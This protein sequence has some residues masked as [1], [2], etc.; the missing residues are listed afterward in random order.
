MG[1]LKH[2]RDWDAV[3]RWTYERE[4]DTASAPRT[5][6]TLATVSIYDYHSPI[7]F[8]L[9]N[10]R[11]TDSGMSEITAELLTQSDGRSICAFALPS[12]VQAAEVKVPFNANEA[13][14]TWANGSI[15]L[16]LT[17]KNYYSSASAEIPLDVLR[18]IAAQG[19]IMT[20]TF[21]RPVERQFA[22]VWIEMRESK[23]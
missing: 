19:G 1:Q 11:S 15:K 4:L 22:K 14:I 12:D 2:Y 10:A 5:I 21:D 3:S 20:V 23:S 8:W 6:R 7:F 13:L 18:Q 16:N 17:K 9:F